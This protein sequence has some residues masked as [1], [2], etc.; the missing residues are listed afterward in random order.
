[1]DEPRHDQ[2]E[3][4]ESAEVVSANVGAQ[5]ETARAEVFRAYVRARARARELAEDVGPGPDDRHRPPS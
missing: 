3:P 1:V 5:V 4:G 2:T